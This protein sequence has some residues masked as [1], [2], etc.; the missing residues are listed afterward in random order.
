VNTDPV[1]AAVP[2]MVV[3]LVALAAGA[4]TY[5]QRGMWGY[6]ISPADAQQLAALAAKPALAAAANRVGVL[7]FD[8]L[9]VRCADTPRRSAGPR[10]SCRLAE[11]VFAA[12]APEALLQTQA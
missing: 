4:Y 10:P 5:A 2:L 3:L 7:E 11:P 1:I 12:R 6:K 8:N 9:A